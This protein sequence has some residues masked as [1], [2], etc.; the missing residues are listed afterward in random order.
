MQRW[1]HIPFLKFKKIGA[2][3][4]Y[5]FEIKFTYLHHSIPTP[6]IFISS[7]R[8]Q[9]KSC[10]RVIFELQ[11]IYLSFVTRSGKRYISAQLLILRYA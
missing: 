2:C 1:S 7:S 4:K 3:W 9:S 10:D 8:K 11:M 5:I 6:Q